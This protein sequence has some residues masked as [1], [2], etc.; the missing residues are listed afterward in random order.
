[1]RGQSEKDIAKNYQRINDII[2]KSNGNLE[3]A[4]SLANQQ[5]KLITN[6]WKAI[7]RALAARELDRED[8]FEIFFTR[9]YELGSVSQMEYRDYV[10]NRLLD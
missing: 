10:I 4:E 1:M 5:A 8:L 2:K 6:E 7:N 9:A 3:K